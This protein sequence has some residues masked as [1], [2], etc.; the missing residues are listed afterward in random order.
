MTKQNKLPVLWFLLGFGIFMSSRASII[1]PFIGVAIIIAPIFIL[2]F[3][4]SQTTKKGNLLTILG[5]LL[6][7][8]IA[9]WG[10]FDVGEATSSLIYN[11]VRSSVL[12][13]L[14]SLPYIADRLIYPK[15]KEHMILSTLSFPIATT[16]IF[17]L[18]SLEG[19]FDGDMISAVYGY[20]NLVFKQI[21]SIAGLWGF[22]FIFSWLASVINY[23]WE[24]RFNWGQIKAVTVTFAFTL[25]AIIIFGAVKTSSL[26]NPESHTVKI[27]AMFLLPEEGEEFDIEGL[28]S[29]APSPYEET[30]S[31]IKALTEEAASKGAKIAAFQETAIKV[32]AKD[33]NTFIEQCKSIA[34]ENNVYFSLGYGVFPDEGKGWNKSILIS[35][36]GELDV[37]Y[38]KRYLLGMGDLF[39]ETLIYNKGPEVIQSADTPYGRIGV[40]I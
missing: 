14:F 1:I 34:V 11:F 20:G 40:S 23:T 25:L 9:L 28:F 3:I 17:F 31:K 27:A 8:N 7:L 29:K 18:I 19:P 26:I 12:A 10:L 38:R 5:F 36:Q 21:A 39:G 30:M 13:L 2:G 37:D 15:L 32:N 33:E 24:K 35:N 4:R 22:V 16:A 6:S